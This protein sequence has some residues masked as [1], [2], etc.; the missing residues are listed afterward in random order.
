MPAYT[1]GRKCKLWYQTD[2]VAGSAGWV[3][4]TN[5]K[6]DLQVD[7][8]FETTEESTRESDFKFYVPGLHDATVTFEIRYDPE[9]AGYVAFENAYD[10]STPIGVK[11]LDG[12]AT[13]DAG[14]GTV[15]DAVIT[16]FSET[17]PINGAVNISVSLQPAPS[18]TPPTRQIPA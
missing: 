12:G 9:N 10:N 8:S 2:G 1:L 6:G 5:I 17:Q 14:R 18:A 3:L 4:M 15:M 11:I 7:R 13:D 16:N